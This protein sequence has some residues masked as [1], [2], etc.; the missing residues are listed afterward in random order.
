MR[1]GLL[2]GGDDRDR[3][4]GH[5][6]WLLLLRR[7]CLLLGWSCWLLLGDSNGRRLSGPGLLRQWW[8]HGQGRG[9][10]RSCGHSGLLGLLRLSHGLS[11][12]GR[13]RLRLGHRLGGRLDCH[14]L[15]GLLDGLGH[16]RRLQ[17]L[18]G[19]WLLLC[20][21]LLGR[22]NH[23]LRGGLGRSFGQ[24]CLDWYRGW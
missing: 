15:L 21:L 3:L 7:W 8:D 14:W 20:R 5:R 22:R 6:D 18:C 24:Y 12:L 2:W 11:C 23:W 9:R 17:R 19:F 1:L 16:H 13:L 4:G 10:R